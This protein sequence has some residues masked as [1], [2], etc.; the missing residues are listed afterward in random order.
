M[1]KRAK[2]RITF[3]ATLVGGVSAVVGTVAVVLSAIDYLGESDARARAT[4]ERNW[5]V[6][7]QMEGKSGDGGRTAALQDLVHQGV[8]IDGIVL[9]KAVMAPDL[10]SASIVRLSAREAVLD[11][12]LFTGATIGE[13]DFSGSSMRAAELSGV[14]FR[15]VEA[16]GARLLDASAKRLRSVGL[17]G[18]GLSVNGADV[19]SASISRGEMRNAIWDN[20]SLVAVE[21]HQVD[22]T[23]A[24]FRRAHLTEA[25]FMG[26]PLSEADFRLAEADHL[27]IVRPRSMQAARFDRACFPRLL[28]EGADARGAS[29]F[30]TGL[31][32]ADFVDA[33]L[34]GANFVA[35]D[36]SGARFRRVN[37]TGADFS[38]ATLRG[39]V[40]VEVD[41]LPEELSAPVG[42]VAPALPPRREGRP[43]ARTTVRGMCS[44]PPA[45][46]HVIGSR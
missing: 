13:S 14:V 20:A 35:A 31:K 15:E 46:G 23:G 36:L 16:A 42:V 27:R 6:L 12:A 34:S 28:I 40:F 29:F 37:L 21:F 9:D 32:D 4:L 45:N 3:W 19:D 7:L 25:L 17:R 26:T 8:T 33:D 30:D 39:T 5:A 38:H 11:S 1:N 18:D 24:S 41:G 43:T 10:S 44:S 22:L 2:E